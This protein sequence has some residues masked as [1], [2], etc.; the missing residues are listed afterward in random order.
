MTI[1]NRF[2]GLSLT[3]ALLLVAIALQ[4]CGSEGPMDPSEVRQGTADGP[5]NPNPGPVSGGSV[6]PGGCPEW[7]TITVQQKMTVGSRSVH[8]TNAGD[9]SGRLFVVEQ[10]GRIR[11]IRDDALLPAPFLDISPRVADGG[12]QGLLSVAFPPGYARKGHFYVSYIR[13]EDGSSTIA[14]YFLSPGNPDVADANSGEILLTVEQPFAIHNA[15]LIAFGPDGYLYLSLG[16]G[17][18]AEDFLNNAQNT[19]SLLGKM[20]RIDVESGAFPYAVPSDNP[21][22]GL[23]GYRE[24]I[25]ALGFRNPWRFSFDRDS[26]DLYIADV[27]HNRWEE[28]NVQPASSRGGENYG[29]NVMEGLNCFT[30]PFCDRTGLTLPTY[31][32]THLTGCSIIGGFVYRGSDYP[33]LEGMYLYSDFCTGGVWGLKQVGGVWQSRLLT[34]T[35]LQIASFGEDE[36]GELFALDLNGGVYT[37]TLR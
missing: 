4:G 18:S 30:T 16:D 5:D 25:W 19:T 12:E 23:N 36:N 28:V 7:P 21:F 34:G 26:R 27:G 32:Y 3:F 14:R 11:V 20:L 15:G 31:Q 35:S 1:T 24:E 33:C 37:V 6:N 13:Q 17:G 2:Q 9:G 10:S 8:I 29:W 22:V